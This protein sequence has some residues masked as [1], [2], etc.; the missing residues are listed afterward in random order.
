MKVKT[1]FL[2]NVFRASGLCT[3]KF[4]YKCKE[5][6]RCDENGNFDK[7]FI[8]S[9]IEN[10]Y[11]ETLRYYDARFWEDVAQTYDGETFERF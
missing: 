4:Y 1:D 7:V 3:K 5:Y 9:R 8:I 2:K 10:K 11:L 6:S